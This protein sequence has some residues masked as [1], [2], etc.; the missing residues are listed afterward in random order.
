VKA[1]PDGLV[2]LSRAADDKRTGVAAKHASHHIARVDLSHLSLMA[3]PPLNEFHNSI[4]PRV[5]RIDVQ[6]GELGPTRTLG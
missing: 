3:L 4:S 1:V 2:R 6:P 5:R